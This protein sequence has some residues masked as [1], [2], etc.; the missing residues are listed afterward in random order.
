MAEIKS[1]LSSRPVQEFKHLDPEAVQFIFAD[2]GKNKN[3]KDE[4][5]DSNGNYHPVGTGVLSKLCGLKYGVSKKITP[6]I[7]KVTDA[8]GKYNFLNIFQGLMSTQSDIVARLARDPEA[9]FIIIDTVDVFEAPNTGASPVYKNTYQHALKQLSN[10]G[11]VVLVA[12]AVAQ[13]KRGRDI[14][15][16]FPSRLGKT[17]AEYP[18]LLVV[19]GVNKSFRVIDDA[20]DW[21][22]TYAPARD[23][24]VASR[25]PSGYWMFDGPL[26]AAAS[27]AGVLATFM[28][29]QNVGAGEALS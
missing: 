16:S 25:S 5:I 27:V 24:N 29:K 10:S 13:E 11:N 6:I 9:K 28:S 2:P 1:W 21:I 7:V 3:R 4:S 12:A 15:Y 20:E 22:K 17:P 8:N 14:T 19:G 18:N 26:M 23:I